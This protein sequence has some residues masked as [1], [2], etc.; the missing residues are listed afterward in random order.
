MLTDLNL[1]GII[2]GNAGAKSIADALKV[3]A[4]LTELN[5]SWNKIGVEASNAIAEA[6]KVNAAY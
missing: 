1:E 4:V 2:I 3:N 5:F 6:L